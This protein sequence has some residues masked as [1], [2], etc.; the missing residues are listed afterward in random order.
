[1]DAFKK[2]KRK[3]ERRIK[4]NNYYN[5]TRVWPHEGGLIFTSNDET[6]IHFDQ[7]TIDEKYELLRMYDFDWVKTNEY[8]EDGQRLYLIYDL[9]RQMEWGEELRFTDIHEAIWS[10]SSFLET[11]D[12]VRFV[13]PPLLTEVK[14]TLDYCDLFL[15]QYKGQS[16]ACQWISKQ[17]D[18]IQVKP[19]KLLEIQRLDSTNIQS[20][21]EWLMTP[22]TSITFS[23][24]EDIVS[25]I[26]DLQDE[27]GEPIQ[28]N[29]E[30][31]ELI[32]NRLG[33]LKFQRSFITGVLSFVRS[34][35]TKDWFYV[36]KF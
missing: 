2:I 36:S 10:F 19:L 25:L 9:Q 31:E 20:I 4:M 14:E 16:I 30:E 3:K 27:Y 17:Q 5:Q 11:D 21:Q 13:T 35:Q 26:N 28:D 32:F 15:L 18:S 22:T 23:L 6:L 24:T 12:E 34:G 8:N 1:M 29:N 33:H 7:L